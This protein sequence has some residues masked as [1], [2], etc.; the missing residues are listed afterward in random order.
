MVP[1]IFL[2]KGTGLSS[3]ASCSVIQLLCDLV[4]A[5]GRKA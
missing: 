4:R 2:R 1:G 3:G 5:G